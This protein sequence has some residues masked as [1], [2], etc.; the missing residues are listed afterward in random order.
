M[1]LKHYINKFCDDNDIT[2]VE[3]AE[4]ANISRSSIY[5]MTS[6]TKS[7]SLLNLAKIAH[8]MQVHPQYLV[9]LEWKKYEIAQILPDPLNPLVEP[10]TWFSSLQDNSH[11][12]TETIADDSM[13][14]VDEVFTKTWRIQNTGNVDW[15]DRWLVCQNHNT[16]IDKIADIKKFPNKQAF[17]LTPTVNKIPIPTTKVGEVVD[18]SVEFTAP[19]VPA[20]ALSYWKMTTAD[21]TICFPNSLGLWVR[22]H[23]VSGGSAY[24]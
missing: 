17:L 11:F 24:L 15:I 2:I 20:I 10:N 16:E 5:N 9:Q 12:V 18:L 3:L 6:D 22:I 14:K 19:S 13:M 1:T 4:R 8:V 7:T 21:G 23:T